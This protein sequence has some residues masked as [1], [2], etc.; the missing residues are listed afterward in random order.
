M[1]LGCGQNRAVAILGRGTH[2][3]CAF[4]IC[5]PI[6]FC[7]PSDSGA[8]CGSAAGRPFPIRGR[9]LR[10]A[11]AIALHAGGER[12][13][14]QTIQRPAL[15]ILNSS[16]VLPAAISLESQRGVLPRPDHVSKELSGVSK[17]WLHLRVWSAL[18]VCGR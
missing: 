4:A 12:L 7:S 15:W 8:G 10:N 17:F 9:D 18:R 11:Y 14:P 1:N 13:D 6:P 5:T 2:R 16:R 3:M